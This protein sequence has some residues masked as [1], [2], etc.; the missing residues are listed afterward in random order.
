MISKLKRQMYFSLPVER[1]FTILLIL[2]TLSC[3]FPF[4]FVIVI[5]LTDEKALQLNGYELLPA[6]WST[7]AYQYLIQ[8]GGQLLRSLGVTIMITVIGTLITVF[9]TGTYAYVL[10]RA[11]FPYRKF[12]TFYLFFTML[13]AGGM[14]PSYLVMTKMLGLKNTIWALILPLA[15][16]PYNV[17]ILR[18]F[19]KKSIPESIIE[20]AKMDGCSEFR[21]FFQ[22]VL[23]LAIPGVA[24]IGLFS[25]L[26]YW[27][28][29]FNALLY[30]DTNKLIP[31][32][33]LLMKI[34]NS[35][36]FLAN[37]NDI[38]L[39]QQQA[40]QNSLPQESTRMA[41]VVVATL[42]IAIVYPF[43]QKYFVQGLT[44]GGVKE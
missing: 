11:S 12:F 2:F 21:V 25:S 37:N 16:S 26:G 13:F 20:S 1:F 5:S 19:F 43:F 40:I 24:T 41:M 18:T 44:I 29:W 31:L 10:S 42:P 6:Q 35:M 38:T 7:D 14:V 23:P 36:E 39:A 17:I 32:Q 34:Q 28:D 8:D 15:F 22:I 3:I 33:Y 4:I 27:N 9:M 30:I